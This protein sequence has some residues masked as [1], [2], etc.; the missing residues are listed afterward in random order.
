MD[1]DVLNQE[2]FPYKPDVVMGFKGQK[3][4]IFVVP[5]AHTMRDT[6]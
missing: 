2:E 5:E 4:G 6:L 3:V 1:A